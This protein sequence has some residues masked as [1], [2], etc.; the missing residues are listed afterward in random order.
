[1]PTPDCIDLDHHIT[2]IDTG[3]VRPGFA[4]SHLIVA[5]DKA[6]FVDV[7]TAHASARLL[8]A[9]E[10]KQ[11]SAEQVEY[12]IVTHVHLDHAGGA[13]KLMSLLPRAKLV[14]HPRGARHMIDP[15][16]LIAGATAVYGEN[17]MNALYGDILPVAE[18]RVII[19]EDGHELMLGRRPL[20]FVDAPGHARHH[21]V[22]WDERSAGFF[23]GDA[24]GLSYRAFD[25]DGQSYIL[26]STS[27]VQF[28]PDA[29]HQT[30]DRMMS[31]QPRHMYLTH[32]GRV[33][34]LRSLAQQLHASI[35]LFTQLARRHP[36][37]GG[38]D[39]TELAR[40][41]LALHRRQLSEQGCLVTD[42]EIQDWLALDAELN[43]QG[44]KIWLDKSRR[45]SAQR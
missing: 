19:A 1:M 15:E 22:V 20:R 42:D 2:T 18:E 7:G 6:A 9:L 21:F 16:K 8:A 40:A 28:E 13:G 38:D 12:V 29:M 5:D 14:V 24:F 31:Y 4:A 36:G 10:P 26:P 37:S 43:A 39:H 35:D 25:H 44:L 30:I 17:K 45:G 34:H 41:L 27:P 33:S 3:Y 11:L 23:S 32:F